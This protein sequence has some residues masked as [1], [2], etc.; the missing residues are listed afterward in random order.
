MDEDL[1]S[2][3]AIP[4]G[5]TILGLS[6]HKGVVVIGSVDV[7]VFTVDNPSTQRKMYL[8]MGESQEP[9]L[10]VVGFTPSGQLAV[11]GTD[12]HSNE[13]TH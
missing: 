5:E 1:V 3:A 7:H 12:D 6:H 8:E 13:V 4:T 10:L 9:P 2:Q 11:A